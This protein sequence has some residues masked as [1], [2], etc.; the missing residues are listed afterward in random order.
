[1]KAKKQDNRLLLVDHPPINFKAD[2]GQSSPQ[3]CQVLLCHVVETKERQEGLRK[4][5]RH[6]D[7]MLNELDTLVLC[8]WHLQGIQLDGDRSAGTPFQ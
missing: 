8:W 6:A 5:R 4:C 2:K 3:L 1:M 7:E